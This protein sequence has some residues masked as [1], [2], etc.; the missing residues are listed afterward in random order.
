MTEIVVR[1]TEPLDGE[2]V[3]PWSAELTAAAA[4]RPARLIVDL[5]ACPRLDAA[6]IVV[7]LRTHGEMLRAHGTLLLRRPPERIRR[8]LRLARVDQVL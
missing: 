8:T 7:L 1:V 6:A 5:T 2:A 4:Q 3:G